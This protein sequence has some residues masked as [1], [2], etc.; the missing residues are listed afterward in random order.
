[1]VAW[2]RNNYGQLGDGSAI[3]RINPMSVEQTSLYGLPLLIGPP[4]SG[5]ELA[6]ANRVLGAG[7]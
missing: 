1:M 5:H 3:T 7:L 6:E 4:C 2:G